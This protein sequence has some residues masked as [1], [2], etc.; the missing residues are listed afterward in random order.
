LKQRVVFKLFFKNLRIKLKKNIGLRF[1]ISQHI[2]D[3]EGAAS[4]ASGALL[5]KS[6]IDYLGCG[7]CYKA[8]NRN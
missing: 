2:R 5:L 6:F 1:S 4:E 8:S 3:K 7:N